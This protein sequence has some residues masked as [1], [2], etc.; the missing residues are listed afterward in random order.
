[1]YGTMY[2]LI[3][4]LKFSITNS[5]NPLHKIW[6]FQLIWGVSLRMKSNNYVSFSSEKVKE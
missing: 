3:L 5:K 4:I 2:I 6:S 1:M